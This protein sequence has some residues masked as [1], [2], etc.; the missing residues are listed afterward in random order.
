[1]TWT[2]YFI[3]TVRLEAAMDYICTNVCAVSSSRFP[4]TART[5]RHTVT[6]AT[7]HPTAGV[8]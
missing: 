6:D 4:L 3:F 8:R 7:D 1:M 2:F 5:Y